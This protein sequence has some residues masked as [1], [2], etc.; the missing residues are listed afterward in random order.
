MDWSFNEYYATRRDATLAIARCIRQEVEALVAAGVKI[1]QVDEPAIS[2][3]V[4]ELD[5]AR[6]A[7][8]LI[9]EGID[10]YFICHI[11]YGNFAPVYRHMLSLSVDNLDLETSQRPEILEDY[12]RGN[13]FDKDISYGVVDVHNHE[14]EGRKKI[15]ETV[16][17]ALDLFGRDSVWIDPDCGLKTRTVDEAVAKLT[18]LVEAVAGCR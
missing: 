4:D 2:T 9:T 16:R 5:F 14:T 18:N 12:V 17:R 15:K 8:A 11:C 1:V 10:A 13:S 3:R 6:E 7:M